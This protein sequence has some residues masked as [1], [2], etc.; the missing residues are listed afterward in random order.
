MRG[1]HDLLNT[2]NVVV[3]SFLQYMQA[4]CTLHTVPNT[5]KMF[6]NKTTGYRQ[7]KLQW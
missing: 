1:K 7:V 4:F 5:L 2:V 3:V 6:M